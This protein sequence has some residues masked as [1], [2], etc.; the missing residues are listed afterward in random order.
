MA[1][2]RKTI[3]LPAE[4]HESLGGGNASARVVQAIR[5]MLAVEALPLPLVKDRVAY[6]GA[7]A[8]ARNWEV[9]RAIR[10]LVARGVG[11]VLRH[12]LGTRV[13]REDLD[14]PHAAPSTV[15]L[16]RLLA[17]EEAMGREVSTDAS[18]FKEEVE[19]V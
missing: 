16:M 4:V 2:E 11:D 14:T 15:D 1:K 8:E 7:L 18:P 9:A 19:E 13:D 17:E 6:L 10:V 5:L 12:E 3:S